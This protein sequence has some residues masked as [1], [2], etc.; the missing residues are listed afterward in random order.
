MIPRKI[1]SS[2]RAGALDRLRLLYMTNKRL[3]ATG[4]SGCPNVLTKERYLLLTVLMVVMATLF[5]GSSAV[6]GQDS[7]GEDCYVGQTVSPGES[8]TYPGTPVEFQVDGT[9]QGR[10][11]FVTAGDE[12][13]IRGT[14]FNDS[15]Y[16]FVAGYR[17][18]G[19]WKIEVVGSSAATVVST[20]MTT[21]VSSEDE[22]DGGFVGRFCDDDGSV[23]EDAI[24]A[25]AGWEVTLGCGGDRFCPDDEIT[26]RQMAAFLYRAVTYKYGA[27]DVGSVA[28][29]DVAEDA[30]YREYAEWA[31]S[32]GVMRAADRRFD[33]GGIVSRAD[34]AEMLVAAFDDVLSPVEIVGWLF[35]DMVGQ[36]PSVVR[37]AEGLHAAG[38][39][40]GCTSSPSLRYCPDRSV[41]RAQMASFF[42]RTIVIPEREPPISSDL[43]G[44]ACRPV[45]IDGT[46]TG[47]PLGDWALPPTGTLRLGVLFMDFDDAEAQYSTH[48]EWDENFSLF[49][50]YIETNSY[51]ALDVEASVPLHR[52]LRARGSH[53]DW[54]EKTR[55]DTG[56]EP[57]A[58][59]LLSALQPLL[60]EEALR[61]A[62]SRLDVSGIDAIMIVYPS[63]HFF[64]GSAASGLVGTD[65]TDIPPAV[66]ISVLPKAADP[67][68]RASRPSRWA[69]VAA[70]ETMHL[71]GLA[72]LYH[73]EGLFYGIE[74]DAPPEH[75]WVAPRTGLMGLYYNL[76][77]HERDEGL[78][79]FENGSWSPSPTNSPEALEMLAWSRWQL[80][81]L[82]ADRVA[83]ITA[84]DVIGR[85]DPVA[86][87]GQ[88]TAMAVIPLS[89]TEVIVVESRRRIGYDDVYRK[90]HNGSLA[91]EPSKGVGLPI[92]GV[93]VYTVN[94]KVA[95]L[96]IPIRVAGDN[97]DGI[98]DRWPIY[99]EGETVTVRG[100]EISV[101]SSTPD[102]DTARIRRRGPSDPTDPPPQTAKPPKLV[103]LPDE[104]VSAPV[105]APDGTYT[106]VTAGWKHSCGLR[107]NGT[108][109][110]WGN[111]DDGQADA[112]DGTYTAIA[113]RSV[114]SCGLRTDGTI[115]CW[116]NNSRGQ[117][118]AP[119]GTYTA[120]TVNL[121]Y[122]C[123]LRT[124]RNIAC[125]GNNS[126]GQTDAPDGT[127]TAVTTSFFHSCGLRTDGTITCWGSNDYGQLNAPGGAYTAVTSGSTHSCGLRTDG[128]ITCWGNN[129]RG[130]TD[131]P[132][133]TYT[134]IAASWNYFCGLR[135]DGA[136]TC[137]GSSSDGQTD[138]P[139]GTFTAV[140]AGNDHS[141]GLRTDGTIT[142]WGS[143]DYGQ[144]NAPGG[145]Y[146]AVT[147]GF[148][149]SCGLRT[150]GAI[151]CWGDISTRTG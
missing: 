25:I 115:T 134:A 24:E 4:A 78:H 117:T 13:S 57:T 105:N 10:F 50:E 90:L 125:W 40:F 32:S 76:L 111:N 85:L 118:D 70:H 97:G 53:A 5:S 49:K 106:A 103:P 62:G 98:V 72:D 99:T 87:R 33:P 131:A 123:G 21:T 96:Q 20:T 112:P 147:S 17:G 136:I 55:R 101:V 43:S 109:I 34:T 107:T 148:F 108:I 124:D 29:A 77:T 19:S 81:W 139:D 122:S 83:C 110:C 44:T 66:V 151:T 126:S 74:E 23:H 18:D 86:V 41:T 15:V 31:V 63:Q 2:R 138:A 22:C 51:G 113:T 54:V 95:S 121:N 135:T 52:W 104:P 89:D 142:C 143:N 75:T 12:I 56:V 69:Q 114:H 16:Y 48:D 79:F 132:D 14:S 7:I 58:S 39:T 94:T 91:Y 100:Y 8:C 129:S 68:Y 133:G 102:G 119:I 137:W 71:F 59:E 120:V 38:V 47:F 60:L 145:A 92:E 144:L 3:R 6:L 93:F 64:G 127:Y 45:G 82:D 1:T 30:W 37:A 84:P 61:L 28:L 146:T 141:C 149:H 65:R 150:D 11:L 116:G 26:R 42:A 140:T 35:E 88:G 73:P 128:A 80:G 9:G 46:Q 130:Q 36:S 67:N 27:P